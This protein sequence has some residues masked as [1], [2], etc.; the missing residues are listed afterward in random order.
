MVA[1]IMLGSCA[2]CLFAGFACLV[3]GALSADPEARLRVPPAIYDK[4]PSQLWNRL[5]AALLV[6]VG[7]DGKDYG[8]D[9]LE[10]LLWKE[11]EYLLVSEETLKQLADGTATASSF[12]CGNCSYDE[13]G[14]VA[15]RH[16]SMARYLAEATVT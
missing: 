12:E 6:R 15:Y 11:S 16:H 2:S 9:R 5:H 7:P 4:K 10:P 8:R 3:E 1:R 14:E 13:I